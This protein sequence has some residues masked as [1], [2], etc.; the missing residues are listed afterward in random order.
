MAT[1]TPEKVGADTAS[2]S[3]SAME[4]EVKSHAGRLSR[5]LGRVSRWSDRYAEYEME[6]G[7]WRKLAL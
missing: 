4:Q 1:F 7:V 3:T 2:Q 5:L 6:R